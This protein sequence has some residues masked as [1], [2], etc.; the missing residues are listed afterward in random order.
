M[1]MVMGSSEEY[2]ALLGFT[3]K[4]NVHCM[5]I[6]EPMFDRIEIE[7]NALQLK[8]VLE[9]VDNNYDHELRL[10][11]RETEH[12]LL[13]NSTVTIYHIPREVNHVA[14]HLAQLAL[15]MVVNFKL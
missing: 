11:L 12:L 7:T 10:V 5:S 15:N 14:H 4:F 6:K 2:Q 1:V 8:V 3:A 13:Q 9:S